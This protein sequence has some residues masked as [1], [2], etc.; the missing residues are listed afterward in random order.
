M[1]LFKMF[2]VKQIVANYK[3]FKMFHVKHLFQIVKNKW[4][5]K[6]CKH[7]C[8]WCEWAFICYENIEETGDMK[9]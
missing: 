4:I 1:K 7:I 2:H 9:K 8:L 3:I 5:N 6:E